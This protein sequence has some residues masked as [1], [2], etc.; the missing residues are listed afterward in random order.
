MQEQLREWFGPTGIG[1]IVAMVALLS[2]AVVGANRWFGKRKREREELVVRDAA[3][4]AD[5]RVQRESEGGRPFLVVTNHGTVDALQYRVT[6]DREPLDKHGLFGAHY[7]T[8]ISD[9]LGPGQ[10]VRFRGAH[11]SMG[12]NVF[13]V[14]VDWTTAKGRAGSWTG[15]LPPR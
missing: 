12:A 14:R 6:V 3:L 4:V 5:V 15:T 13:V 2:G 11:F 10:S 1:T 7:P 9:T 8:G